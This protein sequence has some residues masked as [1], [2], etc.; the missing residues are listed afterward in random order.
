MVTKKEYEEVV[1]YA[2][3]IGVRNA[4]TQDE[5]SISES[6]IPKFKGDTII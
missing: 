4:F 3:E 2:Y 6:F 1:D 5:E